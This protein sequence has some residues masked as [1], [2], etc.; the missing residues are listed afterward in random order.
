MNSARSWKIFL[1]SLIATLIFHQYHFSRRVHSFYFQELLDIDDAPS[2]LRTSEDTMV[3]ETGFVDLLSTEFKDMNFTT[4]GERWRGGVRLQLIK[5][6]RNR[7][8]GLDRTSKQAKFVHDNF[9]RLQK[10]LDD[11]DIAEIDEPSNWHKVTPEGY[12]EILRNAKSS[13]DEMVDKVDLDCV[14][15]LLP[16]SKLSAL[17]VEQD[18]LDPTKINKNPDSGPMIRFQCGSESQASTTLQ[19]EPCASANLCLVKSDPM[20]WESYYQVGKNSSNYNHA[21]LW[22]QFANRRDDSTS[23]QSSKSAILT[24]VDTVKY[25]RGG[26]ST[27][28]K[29][30]GESYFIWECFLNKASYA[31]RTNRDFYIWVGGFEG[32]KVD[33]TNVNDKANT[34]ILHQRN[35]EVVS[36]TFGA[37]CKPEF[38]N[39]NVVHY[40]KPIAFGALFRKLR[41]QRA[42]GDDHK[43]WFVDADIFF[44]KEAF[45]NNEKLGKDPIS[46]DDYFGISPQASLLGSQ[47][48]SGSTDNIL[49]NGGLLGLRG[50]AVEPDDPFD[51]WVL[52]LSALWWYCRCGERDQIALWL[53]LFATWSVESSSTDQKFAYPGVVFENYLFSWFGVF[54]QAQTQL[55]QLQKSWIQETAGNTNSSFSTVP[56]DASLF[57]GGEGF[58]VFSDSYLGGVYT[59][60]LEL[61]HVLLLPLDPFSLPSSLKEKTELRSDHMVSNFPL[62]IIRKNQAEKKALLSHT[63]DKMDVCYSFSCWPFLI[64]ERPKQQK[65]TK[66]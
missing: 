39:K 33:A 54:P 9:Q 1:G 19:E 34:P 32:D 17:Q 26:K 2:N 21:D 18:D 43:I 62:A 44:N 51:D 50:S 13:M 47:N 46:L 12:H 23:E 11:I 53:L 60:P 48:P 10:R 3:Y 4:I 22:R 27:T 14:L 66:R 5:D 55:R 49:I 58:S 41:S 42:E 15:W 38:E 29:T 6:E 31:F 64:R 40:Y 7:M 30:N 35:T 37:S 59:Y 61:P 63:K 36:R 25:L 24:M 56:T 52:N 57:D 20:A 28:S 45:P 8:I 65:N 16:Q